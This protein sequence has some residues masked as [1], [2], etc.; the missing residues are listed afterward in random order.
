MA[1]ASTDPVT[2]GLESSSAPVSG[3]QKRGLSGLGTRIVFGVL[4]GAAGAAVILAGGWIFATATC[5]VVYQASQEFYGFV[6]SKGISQGTPSLSS[7]CIKSGVIL[8]S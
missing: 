2:G 5:L 3:T 1:I 4:L 6:T 7:H 8:L